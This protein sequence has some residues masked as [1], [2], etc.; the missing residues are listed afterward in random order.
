M[1]RLAGLRPTREVALFVLWLQTVI[2]VEHKITI[3]LESEW[4]D[5]A[6]FPPL[7]GVYVFVVMNEGVLDTIAHELCHYEQWRD[8]RKLS[9]RG[10]KQRAAALVKRWYRER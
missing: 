7:D 3:E 9:E 5:G 8:G 4:L 1:I 10:V 2:R 6:F